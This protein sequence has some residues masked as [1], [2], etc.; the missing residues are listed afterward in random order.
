[1]APLAFD[2]YYISPAVVVVLLLVNDR[3][4]SYLGAFV[5]N[6]SAHS[7]ALV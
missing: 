3:V 1:M 4:A 2:L 6:V 7:L 5:R